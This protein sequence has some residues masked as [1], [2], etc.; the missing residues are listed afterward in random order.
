MYYVYILRSISSGN[1]YK[2]STGDLKQRLK[3]HNDG[4]VRSTK[5][6]KPFELIYYEAFQSKTDA[7]REEKFLKTGKGKERVRYLLKH[8]FS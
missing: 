8:T 7:L 3:R 1:L 5:S 6:L 2:G 4:K